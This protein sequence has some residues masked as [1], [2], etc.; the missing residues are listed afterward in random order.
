[1][2]PILWIMLSLFFFALGEAMSKY[3]AEKQ[4]WWL[5][6]L[7]MIAYITCELPWFVAIKEKSLNF[8][9]YHLERW[10]SYRHRLIRVLL[11]QRR[12]DYYTMDWYRLG[13]C[14]LLVIVLNWW[15]NQLSS[16]WR[17]SYGSI[18]LNWLQRIIMFKPFLSLFRS[19]A[20]FNPIRNTNPISLFIILCFN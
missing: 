5:L 4:Y 9:C 15:I 7:A 17:V 3:W 12:C 8:T 1:M 11:V 18:I 10:L 16:I 6:A 2:S 20:S 14:C 19:L 13:D